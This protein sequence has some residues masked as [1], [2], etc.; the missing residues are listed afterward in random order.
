[1]RIKRII[2]LLACILSASLMTAQNRGNL[3]VTLKD[4]Q[5]DEPVGFATVSL[6]K[7]G[8]Q[9]PYKYALTDSE[10][11]ATIE[12]VS[13]GN[14]VF[15]AEIMGYKTYTK[16]IE[17]GGD[18]ALGT[19]KMDQD[20]Q[21]LD[22]AS[23]SATGNPIIIKKD[24]IEYN[25]SSFKTT[26][27]D[28]LEDLLKKLPGV[29]VS[30]D[31]TVTANGQTISKITIDGK[32]FF[33]DDPQLASKNLPAKIIE[34][35]KV[36]QKKSE[37]AEFTGIDDG[38]EETIIDLNIQKGMMNG[39]FG[40][41][42]LGGGHDILDNK[43][44]SFGTNNGDYRYQGGAFIGK[45]TD[46]QQIS[47][48]LNGNNTN[49]RGFNDLAGGMMSGMRGGGGGM[50]RGQGGWGS[51]N[52]ITR[53]WMGGLNGAW[54]L[55]DGDMSLGGNYVYNNT[56]RSV[57]ERSYKRTAETD[58]SYIISRNGIDSPGY[59]ITNSY[60]NRFGMRLEHKF[61][62]NTSILFQPQIN[63][64]GGD[65]HEYSDFETLEERSG[66]QNMQNKG[67][68]NNTGENKNWST[69]G[70]FLFRQRLGIPGR[71]LSFMGNYNFSNND[72]DG[73]TQSLTE[74]YFGGE[75]AQDIV[76]QRIDR[77]TRSSSLSGRLVYTEPL[78]KGF[79]ASANYSYRWSKNQSIKDA[80]NSGEVNLFS[81]DNIIYNRN[82]ETKD[83]TYSS[84]IL[85]RY[86]N[87]SAGV[88]L[89]YQK[90]KLHAQV[91]FSVM[92]TKTHNVTNGKEYDSKVLNY[93]PSAMFWYD[94]SDNSNARLFYRGRSSQPSTTQLMPVPDNSNPTSIS[95]GNPDLRPYFDH[96][97]RGEFRLTN[98]K[99]FMSLNANVEGSLVQDPIVSAMWYSKGVQ[100][101][102]PVNGPNSGNGSLRLFFNMPI[103]KSNFSLFLMNRTSYS[104][105]TSYVGQ[106]GLDMSKYL[107][108]NGTFTKYDLFLK[109]YPDLT[110]SADFAE[111]VA[112]TFG[113]MQRVRLTYRTDN[114]EIMA[115]GRTRMSRSTY[116]LDTAKDLKT[117]NNQV[118]ASVNLTLPAGFTVKANVDY[119]WYNG[120]T[121]PQ[122]DEVIVNAEINKLLFKDRFT[123]AVR[124][125]DLLNQ[126]KNLS[127]SDSNGVYKETWNNTL[128]RYIIVA[129]TYRFGTFGGQRGG[130]M[131]MGPGGRMGGPGGPPPMR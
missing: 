18:F 45:F 49:N 31:G 57:Q 88:D 129:L 4:S 108:E 74:S 118:D 79:Y 62:E 41:I 103:A 10:G 26:D 107:D 20:K 123:L 110:H 27:N 51:G 52:G 33:L 47:L 93:A 69:N 98:K 94:F 70:F 6:T 71:T 24:T 13:H 65:Y 23:V 56:N 80:Y 67:F 77:N 30:E 90:D 82:G 22:A 119:N 1:M 113:V 81:V 130:G 99:S 127:V 40:N 78:G 73:F 122:D 36:V 102:F 106:T 83:E 131:R 5:T 48:I 8:E 39:M 32:T 117:W 111:N 46:K 114:V 34:K 9:K 11:K 121:T 3:T 75:T 15:K 72:L 91:G 2:V 35:V 55:F 50:G 105:S 76:N 42:S 100:Y 60:G 85:N 97:L 17:L 104:F 63:F 53:S 38:E 125:Y 87:Q 112:R 95:L 64:G 43:T 58:G 128:G 68:S 61:S 115:G 109:D 14:Y 89:Q 116:T 126:A 59:N 37:Q 21:V 66:I 7:S 84:D 12:R 44:T 29:E 16:A 25:A 54:D 120:Y 92:P 28:M 19:I 96:G 86:N 101:T 124:G